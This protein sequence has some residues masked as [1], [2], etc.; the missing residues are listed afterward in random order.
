MKSLKVDHWVVT[1]DGARGRVSYVGKQ[2]DAEHGGYSKDDYATIWVEN[3]AEDQLTLPVGELKR[4]ADPNRKRPPI[5]GMPEVRPLC[6]FCHKKLYPMVDE[7]KGDKNR[8]DATAEWKK[9]I[10]RRVFTGWRGY[11]TGTDDKFCSLKCA[12]AFARAAFKAGYRM[13]KK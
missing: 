5:D 11:T 6:P 10:T 9:P 4:I 7:F 12:Y 1:A 8:F 2:Y 13:V 3:S